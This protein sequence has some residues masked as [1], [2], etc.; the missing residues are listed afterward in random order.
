MAITQGIAA[1]GG[2]GGGAVTIA[3]GDDACLGFKAETAVTGDNPGTVSAKLRGLNKTLADVWN[4]TNHRLKTE[5]PGVVSTANSSTATLTANSVFTGTSEDISGVAQINVNV[6]SDQ[7]SAAN[8]L[9]VQF[10]SDGTNWDMSL[11]ESVSAATGASFS[12]APRAKFY[13]LVYTNGGTNQTSFRLQ[14][15]FTQV[16]T[17]PATIAPM[18]DG[19]GNPTTFSVA[20]MGAVYNGS[21]WD[22]LRDSAGATNT[23]TGTLASGVM[24]FDTIDA[25]NKRVNSIASAVAGGLNGKNVIAV[26]CMVYDGSAFRARAGDSSG[27]SIVVGAAAAGA[28]AAGNPVLIGGSNAGNVQPPRLDTQNNTAISIWAPNSSSIGANVTAPIDGASATATMLTTSGELMLYNGATWD[29]LRHA[30][31]FKPI[32]LSAG[33]AETAIWTPTSGKKFRVMGF[34]LTPGAASTLTFK[35][36]TGG[37]TILAAR[38]TTDQPIYLSPPSSNGILS[39]AANNVLTVTRGTSCT[40]DGVVFGTEE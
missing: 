39:S 32:A 5:H 13:R 18:M 14:T 36:N 1:S 6:F 21:T 22:R 31:V 37:T 33:T 11:S 34:I 28:P 23:T 9:Q 38:G 4:S 29:R 35:D 15:I 16:R 30:N 17:N 19:R 8:G 26:G 25:Q 20:S 10:S 40:L 7:A 24:V 2:G 27:R 3:D 12:F